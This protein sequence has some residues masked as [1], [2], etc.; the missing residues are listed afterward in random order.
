MSKVLRLHNIGVDT[1]EDWQESQKYGSSV[2]NQI[3]DPNGASSKREI[4]SI[5]SPFARIDLVKSA[6]K[7]VADSR[8][9]NGDTIFHKMVSDSLDVAEIFFKA[10]VYSDK[11][12]IVYWDRDEHLAELMQGNRQHKILAQTIQMYLE[13]DSEAYNFDK[14]RRIYILGYVGD[15]RKTEFDVLGATSPATLFFSI[16]NDLSYVSHEIPFNTDY[17]FDGDYNPL[18]GRDPEFVKYLFALRKSTKNFATLFPEVND[19]LDL[20]YGELAVSLKNEISELDASSIDNYEQLM[21][22]D[23]NNNV[24]IISGLRYHT[25]IQNTENIQSDFQ[26][27][28]SINNDKILVLPV[29]RG[30]RYNG[31]TLT[32]GHWDGNNPAPYRN[33]TEINKRRLPQTNE[34]YPYLTISDFLED[35]I[36][37]MPHKMNQ[38]YFDPSNGANKASY[39]LPLKD[40]FFEFFTTEELVKDKMIEFQKNT[41]GVKV[42]LH[43][44]VD[45]GCIDYE[46]LYFENSNAN[47]DN[48]HN[49]G[50]LVSK[51]DH[52]VFAMMPLVKFQ[53]DSDANYRF[54]LITLLGADKSKYSVDF[55][56]YQ[57]QR[58][59]N[60]LMSARNTFDTQYITNYVYSIEKSNV[61]YIR[62][63]DGNVSGV[64]LPL[65]KE[66]LANSKFTFSVDFGTSNTHIVYKSDNVK[67]QSFDIAESDKQLQIGLEGLSGNSKEAIF[68]ELTPE[69][70]GDNQLAKFPMRSSLSVAKNT[71]WNTPTFPLGQ[72]NFAFLYEKVMS[73][74]YNKIETNLKWSNSVENESLI[75]IYIESLFLFMRNKVILNDGIL[76]KTRIIWTY[77]LSMTRARKNQFE[78]VWN[79]AYQKYFGNDLT[80][81]VSCNESVAP[82]Y[83]FK[84]TNPNVNNIVTIDIGGGTSDIVIS[85][86]NEVKYISSFRFASNVIFGDLNEP[87]TGALNG[88]VRQFQDRI[89]TQLK[90][91]GLDD[92]ISIYNG[93]VKSN[94]SSNISSLF[95][96]LKSNQELMDKKINID[97][98][99]ELKKDSY[100]KITYLLFYCAIVYHLAKI[101]KGKQL[102]MP[103]HIGFSGNGSKI[104]DLITTETRLLEDLSKAIF[105]KVY[106]KNSYDGDGLSILKIDNPKEATSMG[107]IFNNK[108]EDFSDISEKRIVLL[109][110]DDNTFS[111]DELLY[112]EVNNSLG[113]Y[114]DKVKEEA[115]RFIDFFFDLNGEKSLSFTNSFGIE[116]RAVDIAKQ[117]CR[118]D[119]KTYAENK[120]YQKINEVNKEDMVEESMFFYPL[121]GVIS[122]LSNELCDAVLN[123]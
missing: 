25:K 15:K 94:N 41:G 12:K 63:S 9:L 24:E 18:N 61:N 81:L 14:M 76:D 34:V 97:F 16:A 80:N 100:Q 35:T 78:E 53:N 98:S 106:G 96:S 117:I 92:L 123:S 86:H 109:G 85:A 111:T 83:Y 54:A 49:D 11:I 69:F 113:S 75:R 115:E 17:P 102:D 122:A 47:I 36:V 6:F 119:I 46:R 105:M 103:R 27:K 77:P 79:S 51:R 121:S 99:N 23:G 110:I 33:N 95:F 87:N 60:V 20:V 21:T 70:V 66:Q 58:I 88:I 73:P 4:T 19:Y 84:S 82:Y 104:L 55:M 28:S 44:P 62:I 1:L 90:N 5:P 45:G 68:S 107:S 118:R 108:R 31:L 8:D 26:I 22:A 43:I 74:S 71:N 93:L 64:L 120:F 13:Q 56:D 2:I 32:Q 37:R 112:S 114:V 52:F 72:A 30:S 91:N 29:E 39:L 116:Q 89:I 40:K 59:P 38:N 65:F 10:N 42:V 50:A 3:D 67:T 48:T 57:N 101:M 7:F